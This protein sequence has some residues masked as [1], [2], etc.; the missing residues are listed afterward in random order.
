MIKCINETFYFFKKKVLFKL[1]CGYSLVVKLLPSIRA[2][3][4]ISSITKNFLKIDKLSLS[5]VLT[6]HT[7]AT[8]S[9]VTLWLWCRKGQ[10]QI[11]MNS[12]DSIFLACIGK[13]HIFPTCAKR[14][15]EAPLRKFRWLSAF[16]SN[17]LK[18]LRTF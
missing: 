4:S 14:T 1:W 9:G 16:N 10:C 11:P 3:V 12:S 5:F 17:I 7:S 18:T 2:L 13:T 15:C 6:S 8:S